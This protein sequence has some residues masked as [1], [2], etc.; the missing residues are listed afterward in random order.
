MKP[1]PLRRRRLTRRYGLRTV[2]A[3]GRN[4]SPFAE[5]IMVEYALLVGRGALSSLAGQVDLLASSVNWV[6]VGAIVGGLLFV[7]L[8]LKPPRIP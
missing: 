1:H 3:Q 6:L 8:A 5:G 4:G 2:N 7:R